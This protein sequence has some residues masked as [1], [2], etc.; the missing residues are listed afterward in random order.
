MAEPNV[1]PLAFISR[2]GG[3]L[4]INLGRTGLSSGSYEL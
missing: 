3:E 4:S 1:C 2:L